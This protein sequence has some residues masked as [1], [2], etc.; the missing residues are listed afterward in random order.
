MP[1]H[2]KSGK[3]TRIGLRIILPVSSMT[4]AHI[5]EL[6]IAGFFLL[7]RKKLILSES[8]KVDGISFCGVFLFHIDTVAFHWPQITQG[9]CFFV[10]YQHLCKDRVII[11]RTSCLEKY[12]KK[13][14]GKIAQLAIVTSQVN[15]RRAMLHNV[16]R[17]RILEKNNNTYK[18]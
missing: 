1:G 5:K 14:L 2:R 6:P 7:P 3:M 16:H 11:F 17:G 8:R 12:S 10:R 4:H 9:M 15:N 18:H 13:L